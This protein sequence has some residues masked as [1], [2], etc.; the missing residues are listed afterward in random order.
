MTRS[1]SDSNSSLEGSLSTADLQSLSR[2]KKIQLLTLLEEKARRLSRNKIAT[3]YPDEGEFRRELYVGHLEHFKLGAMYSERALFGG[4]RT[5]KTLAGSYEMTAHLTGIYPKWWE[6]WRIKKHGDYW[7]AGDTSKTVR[8]ILQRTLIGPPGDP[9][10][11]GTAMIPGDLIARTTP[12]HGLADAVESVYVRHVDGAL[13]SLQ[14]KSFDQGRESFQG[15][16]QHGIMLDEDCPEDIYVECLM[17]LMTTNGRLWW[18]A[19]LVEGITPLMLSFL[20]HLR[21]TV[22]E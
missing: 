6:G 3:L 7:C 17:R 14:F 9:D 21:P 13:S 16:E 19:T 8:D 22:D 18:T 1:I 12:K 10:Q 11:W 15:T 5:G 20:P 2:T 4:N